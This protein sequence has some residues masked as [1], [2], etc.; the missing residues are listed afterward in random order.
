M[1]APS[2][3]Q[4]QQDANGGR[5]EGIAVLQYKLVITDNIMPLT[6]QLDHDSSLLDLLADFLTCFFCFIKTQEYIMLSCV[7]C[8]FRPFTYLCMEY[9]CVCEYV[10][11]SKGLPTISCTKSKQFLFLTESKK[12]ETNELDGQHSCLTNKYP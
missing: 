9:I 12:T 11:L 2:H 5:V 3:R 7:H 8:N 4:K 6:L 1:K 10:S